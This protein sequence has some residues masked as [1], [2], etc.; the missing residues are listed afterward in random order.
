M[1]EREHYSA[2]PAVYRGKK[3]PKAAKAKLPLDHGRVGHS[4]LFGRSCRFQSSPR[5]PAPFSTSLGFMMGARA[6]RDERAS[7][8]L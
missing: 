2:A 6:V 5:L 1:Q 3:G 4:I 8:M 7:S